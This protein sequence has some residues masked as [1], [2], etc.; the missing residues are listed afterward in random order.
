LC[1]NE[2]VLKSQNTN[3]DNVLIF[4]LVLGQSFL[5]LKLTAEYRYCKNADLL[6]VVV[7]GS[8]KKNSTLAADIQ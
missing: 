8:K 6:Y 5:I 7:R 1:K 3:K 4:S 2:N